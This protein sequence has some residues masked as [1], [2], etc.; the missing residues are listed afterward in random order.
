MSLLFWKAGVI[1]YGLSCLLLFH[2]LL[3]TSGKTV[4][5]ARIFVRAAFAFQSVGILFVWTSLGSPPL[6]DLS[7]VLKMF[8]WL[9]MCVYVLVEKRFSV[10]QTGLVIIP[11]A[12]CLWIIGGPNW[13]MKSTAP[14][15]DSGW[16]TVHGILSL[17]GEGSLAVAFSASLLY[18]WQ[19]RGIKKRKT[20]R[21]LE[22]L[23][24][25]ESLDEVNYI[26]L[27]LGFLFLTAG[28]VSGAI[29]AS[30]AWGSYW[31]WQSKE[32]WALATWLV[33]G[34][35]LHQRLNSGWRG[36]KGALLSVAGFGFVIITFVGAGLLGSGP[37]T[38]GRL[39][40]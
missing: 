40:G 17:L 1:L 24:S 30:Q 38:F 10:V 8:S 20:L 14:I 2:H 5:L 22:R 21:H 25:L 27:G 16:L 31:T 18:L 32:T 19:E 34:G 13:Q 7:S 33:Y 35:V 4:R 9:I 37:H 12:T 15:F 3:G 23:P 39:W 11:M 6:W 28:I 26:C 36:R 29:W